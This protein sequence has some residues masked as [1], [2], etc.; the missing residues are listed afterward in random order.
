MA[1][2]DALISAWPNAQGD[3]TAGKLSWL[4]SQTV[5]GQ[6]PKQ[7]S[8]TA[9]DLYNA[10][11][12]GEWHAMNLDAAAHPLLP[13]VKEI[14]ALP[15]PIPVGEGTIANLYLFNL[16]GSSQATL[17]KLAALAVAQVQPWWKASGYPRPFDLGDVST[18]GLS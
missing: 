12:A 18:A 10:F 2:Y 11:D 5:T 8:V 13:R 3:T 9:T 4:N 16:F 6:P 17:L 7:F 15:G 1:Y 14:L